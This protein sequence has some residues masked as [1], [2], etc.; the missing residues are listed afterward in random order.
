MEGKGHGPLKRSSNIFKDEGNFSVR[1]RAPRKNKRSLV[2]VL[3]FNLDLIIAREVD[4]KGV[5]FTPHTLI[6]YLV[7]KWCREIILR[8]SS[9]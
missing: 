4:H 2:L 3:E 9:I 1:K 8:T 7:I 6:Q 5:N